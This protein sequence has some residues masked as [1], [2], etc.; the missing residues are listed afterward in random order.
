MRRALILGGSLAGLIVLVLAA[1]PLLVSGERFQPLLRAQLEKALARPVEIGACSLGMFPPAL[2][3]D[4]LAI[5]EDPRAA[6]T[7]PFASAR[8]LRVQPRL[9]TLLRGQVEIASLRLVQPAI[10]LIEMADG[11]WN[12]ASLGG[13]GGGAQGGGALRL[14][15]LSAEDAQFALTTRARGRTVYP[16]IDLRVRDIAPGARMPIDLAANIAPGQAIEFHGS[17]APPAAL[18]GKLSLQRCSLAALLAFLNRSSGARLDGALTGGI[19]FASRKD[20]I[21]AQGKLEWTDARLPASKLPYT[22]AADFSAGSA[23]SLYR[24][25]RFNTRLGGLAINASGTVNTQG[26]Q[27]EL[28]LDIQI[29]SASITELAQ[30]AAGFG[31]AFSPQYQVKGTVSARV[32]ARGTAAAPVFTGTVD[33]ANL[34]AAGGEVKQPVRT[35]RIALELTPDVIRSRP[36]EVES[37][38]TK[39]TAF[40]ALANYSQTP[41]LEASAFAA[42]SNLADL[43]RMAQAYG[44]SAAQG[45][46]ASGQA[47]FRLRIHGPLVKG[48]A[49]NYSGDASLAGAEVQLPSLTKPVRVDKASLKF[50]AD[51]A[52][53]E[54]ASLRIGNSHLQGGLRVR[55]FSRPHLTLQAQ[56][57]RLAASEMKG[58]LKPT[59]GAPSS[60]P[61]RLT[62]DGTIGIG[63]LVLEPLELTAVKSSFTF[64][65]GLLKLEPITAGGYGGQ[66]AGA[67][68]VDTRSEPARYDVRTRLQRVDSE[69]LLAAATPLRKILTG[70]LS[71][72]A[73]LS[74]APKPNEDLART[75]S[76]TMSLKLADGKLLPLSLLG[77]L[78]AL[79]QFV[80]K[81]A[82]AAGSITPLLGLSG[83][84]NF[85]NGSAAT[86]NLRLDLDAGSATLAGALDLA[87]QTVNMKMLTTLSKRYADEAGGTRIG[88]YLTTAVINQKGEM[89]IPSLIAGPLSR[90]RIT[91]DAV[92]MGKLKL[93]H[94]LPALGGAPGSVV[95]AIKGDKEGVRSILDTLRGKKKQQQQ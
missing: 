9:L 36:F 53:V 34:E 25:A 79:A 85:Q 37:G 48:T 18:D 40:F 55:N 28:A 94:A 95:D 44:V 42:N 5:G 69:Q 17:A 66:V 64:E 63:K 38:P 67:I 61:P 89:L 76:G 41:R 68:T 71:G 49:L 93:Q 57:D 81:Q 29:P 45:A 30:L 46:S 74:F 56:V 33:I 52:V 58:L 51:S 47:A 10:E 87:A 11:S 15:S 27:P 62:A 13:A 92:A 35:G 12:T 14:N 84:L 22:I 77:E 31:A 83:D 59:P 2:V 73:A 54:N 1:L 60:A 8:E 7:R 4:R 16:H 86:E 75:L 90:P 70:A 3:V 78:G 20:G 72:E 88:G 32:A 26:A 91:P 39:L 24:I 19:E 21:A 50:E 6:S 65:N 82:P 80:N 43:V 23:G